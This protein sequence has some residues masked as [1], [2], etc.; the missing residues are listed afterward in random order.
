MKIETIETARLALRGFTPGLSTS[1]STPCSARS[2]E[3]PLLSS[4]PAGTHTPPSS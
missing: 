4:Q 3:S 1:I 2:G